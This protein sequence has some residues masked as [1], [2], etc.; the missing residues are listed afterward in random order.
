[1]RPTGTCINMASTNLGM[2]PN[3]P[4]LYAQGQNTS[5]GTRRASR[6][7]EARRSARSQVE[8][9]DPARQRVSRGDY[10][11][12]G[13]NRSN[14]V[15]GQLSLPKLDLLLRGNTPCYRAT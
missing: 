13:G 7:G 1:M 11:A 4:V 6:R 2:E 12:A 10:S 8:P 9:A 3:F 14:F 5:E 15:A